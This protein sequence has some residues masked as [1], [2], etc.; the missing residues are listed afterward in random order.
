MSGRQPRA[1]HRTRTAAPPGRPAAWRHPHGR[2]PAAPVDWPLRRLAAPARSLSCRTR[3]A[4]PPAGRP[5][6]CCPIA[7]A[8]RS[9]RCCPTARAG[10][11]Q[12]H[13]RR[14]APRRPAA[15]VDWPPRRLAAPVRP[16]SRRTRT[17]APPADRSQRC[18]PTARADRSQRRARRPAPR[19]PAAPVDCP[20]RRLAAPV[21][22]LSRRTGCIAAP[23]DRLHRA[24]PAVGDRSAGWNGWARPTVPGAPPP[25]P[26]AADARREANSTHSR[27]KP[28]AGEP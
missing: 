6:R 21:R 1:L 8:D 18:C 7:S 12:R 19:R 2:C 14:P 22:P 24:A 9:P 26:G 3:T 5:P 11:P 23:S 25:G 13:A 4:A 10:R 20:P 28:T 16:L 17:A 15:P 27:P